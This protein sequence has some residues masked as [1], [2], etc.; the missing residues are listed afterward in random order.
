MYLAKL[1]DSKWGQR[2]ANH[3]VDHFVEFKESKGIRVHRRDGGR[4]GMALVR[5]GAGSS[6]RP[7][8]SLNEAQALSKLGY[9]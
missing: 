4:V 7:G 6:T 1:V 3:H 9:Y 5:N 8:I 2:V